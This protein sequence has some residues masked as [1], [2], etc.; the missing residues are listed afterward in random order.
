MDATGYEAK[1]I[2]ILSRRHPELKLDIIGVSSYNVVVGEE[3]I[4]EKAG[5]VVPGLYVVGGSAATLYNI[6]RTG[7]LIG[8]L[9]ESSRKV[10]LQIVE[11]LKKEETS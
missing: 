10:A 4:I 3:D 1:L 6:N 5:M 7:A 2:K 9:L 8:C 11:D